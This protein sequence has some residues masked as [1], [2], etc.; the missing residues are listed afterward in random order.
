[1]EDKMTEKEAYLVLQEKSGL[2]IGDTV[3]VLR[4]SKNHELGWDNVWCEE[5]MDCMV[6]LEFTIRDINEYGINLEELKFPFFVLEKIKGAPKNLKDEKEAY[7]IL[8]E[9]SG[10][11]VG[12]TVKVL[13]KAKDY[14]W[15]WSIEWNDRYMD[16]FI[17]KDFIIED[18]SNLGIKVIYEIDENKYWFLPFFVLEKIADAKPKDPIIDFIEKNDFGCLDQKRLTKELVQMI[19]DRIEK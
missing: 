12:D 6:G 15:G 2:K 5:E 19:L 10:L 1:M 11:K 18:V 14:E 17:G 4:K 9:K 3:K 8:Q 7:L 16:M 13:R